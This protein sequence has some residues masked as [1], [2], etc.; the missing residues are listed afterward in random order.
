MRDLDSDTRDTEAVD[1]GAL[2]GSLGFLLRLSQLVSFR[3]F[4]DDLGGFG[5]RPGEISALFVIADNPGIRQGV[6]ARHLMIKRAH[7]AKMV[8]AMESDGL[9]S[10]SVPADDRRAVELK[11]TDSGRARVA[12]LSEPFRRHEARPVPGLTRR[13]EAELKRLLRKY[14]SLPEPEGRP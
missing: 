7:M 11:L 2:A 3:D 6:V 5:I 13:D 10:R 12:T 8:R 14:L 1:L 9:V 4:Y